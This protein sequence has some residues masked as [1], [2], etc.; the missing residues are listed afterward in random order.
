[1]FDLTKDPKGFVRLSISGQI[2][3]AEMREGIEAFLNC[4]SDGAKTNFLYT[5]SDFEFPALSA[6]AVEFGYFPR[7]LSAL[8]RIGKVAL[9][10]D[11][12]WLRGAAEIE[13][14]LIPGLTIETFTPDQGAQAEAWLMGGDAPD[15]TAV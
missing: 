10:A 5:I 1:M 6:I 9:V 4:L 14:F 12:A 15:R 7:L 11:A 2:S 13:G 8:P 3:D